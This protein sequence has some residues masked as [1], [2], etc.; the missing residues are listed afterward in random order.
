MSSTDLAQHIGVIFV[1][2]FAF[3]N[4]CYCLPLKNSMKQSEAIIA[5][6]NLKLIQIISTK[7]THH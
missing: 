6:Q 2:F 3:L 1:A 7:V 5:A 4:F